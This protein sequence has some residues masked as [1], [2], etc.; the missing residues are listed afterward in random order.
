MHMNSEIKMCFA[1]FF[2]KVGD[3]LTSFLICCSQ[4][5]TQLE[6]AAKEEHN[7]CILCKLPS[8]RYYLIF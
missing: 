6:A 3:D 5:A 4:F 8:V 7:V 2:H 1:A